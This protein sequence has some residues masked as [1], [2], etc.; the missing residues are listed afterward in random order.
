MRAYIFGPGG[1]GLLV[2]LVDERGRRVLVLRVVWFACRNRHQ[3]APPAHSPLGGADGVTPAVNPDEPGAVAG[4][5]R[6]GS[7]IGLMHA[8]EV[9]G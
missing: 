5:E 9:L 2:A 4:G 7:G 1:R 3:P 6:A 8:W